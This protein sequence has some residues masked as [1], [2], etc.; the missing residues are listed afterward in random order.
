M[1]VGGILDPRPD[2]SLAAI[3][4][5]LRSIDVFAVKPDGTLAAITR[6]PEVGAA[7]IGAQSLRIYPALII[8]NETWFVSAQ[9]LTRLDGRLTLWANTQVPGVAEHFT[10]HELQ[11][12]TETV[13]D[14]QLIKTMVA[15]EA[16]NGKFLTA[17]GGGGN[18]VFARGETVAD[19]EKWRLFPSTEEK[20]STV[21]QSS[22]GYYLSALDHGGT[23]VMSTGQRPET[24]E[25]FTIA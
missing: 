24:W 3:S 20:S 9:H 2:C 7:L 25:R 18:F 13:G 6:S 19:W 1:T 23:L 12:I 22:N 11:R 17:E 15:I 14:Q 5:D 8:H 16:V 21:F 4:R 10:I